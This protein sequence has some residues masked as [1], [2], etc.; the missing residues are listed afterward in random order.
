MLHAKLQSLLIMHYV[1]WCRFSLDGLFLHQNHKLQAFT[2]TRSQFK[3]LTRH[4]RHHKIDFAGQA[5]KMGS[6]MPSFD[7]CFERRILVS[8]VLLFGMI[9]PKLSPKT[10]KILGMISNNPHRCIPFHHRETVCNQADASHSRGNDDASDMV[11]TFPR[12]DSDSRQPNW[13]SS[14]TVTKGIPTSNRTS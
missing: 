3:E 2:S 5:T 4:H 11:K 6:N 10:K 14:T 8:L 7:I 12:F 13:P 1:F 9:F